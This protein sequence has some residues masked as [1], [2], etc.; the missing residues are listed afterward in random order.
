MIAE[1]KRDSVD[2]A[3]FALRGDVVRKFRFLWLGIVALALLLGQ[4][5]A[6]AEYSCSWSDLADAAKQ[7]YKSA[8]EECAPQLANPIYYALTV[9]LIAATQAPP[10]KDFCAGVEYVKNQASDKQKQFLTYWDKLPA[11]QQEKLKN[12]IPAFADMSSGASDVSGGLDLISCACKTAQWQGPGKV[13][14]EWSNCVATGMCELQDWLHDNVWSEIASCSNSSTPPPPPMDVDCT[15]DPHYQL[16][17]SAYWDF[18]QNVGYVGMV[19]DCKGWMD[20]TDYDGFKCEGSFC[21]SVD[22]KTKGTGNYCYCPENM[23]LKGKVDLGYNCAYYLKCQCRD[24]EPLAK[25]G[26]GKFV[27][28]C[29]DGLPLGDNEWCSKP[30]KTASCDCSCPNNTVLISKDE[31][32]CT[33]NCG[34]KEG[35]VKIGDQCVSQCADASQVML[36]SGKCCAPSQAAACGDCCPVGMT[37][38]AS[39]GVCMSLPIKAS[40]TPTG[41]VQVPPNQKF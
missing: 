32:A 31:K 24:G 28:M 27:C 7:A 12:F 2:G 40:V 1:V 26:A 25:E 23:Q 35:D 36:A 33:C 6:R 11:D 3:A 29:P 22:I 34:C 30:K 9:F 16:P 10:G 20:G 18:N 37:P 8:P 14:T 17:N 5:P 39:S 13:Y 38:D 4:A 15:A 19:S 21:A 41:P